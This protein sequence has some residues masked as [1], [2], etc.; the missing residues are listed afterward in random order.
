MQGDQPS[1]SGTCGHGF[2]HH[3][4]GRAHAQSR[5]APPQQEDDVTTTKK[6]SRRMAIRGFTAEQ[7]R[8]RERQDRALEH[9]KT[10]ILLDAAEELQKIEAQREK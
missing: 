4:L 6:P 5:A 3:V 2:A 8:E 10:N 7:A 1:M 9:A